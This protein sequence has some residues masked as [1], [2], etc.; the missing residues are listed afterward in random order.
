MLKVTDDMN[1]P[2]FSKQIAHKCQ[3]NP[4]CEV[5]RQLVDQLFLIMKHNGAFCPHSN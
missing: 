5:Y 1:K 4:R 2:N 3:C